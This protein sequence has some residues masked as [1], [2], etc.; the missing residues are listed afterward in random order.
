LRAF[1]ATGRLGRPSQAAEEL[2]ISTSAISHQIRALEVFLGLRM[3]ERTSSGLALTTAGHAYNK[4][5][6]DAFDA[7]STATTEQM[8]ADIGK[9]LKLHMFQSLVNLWLIP[10]LRDLTDGLPDL[11]ASI[12]SHPEVASLSASDL[13][14]A[15]VYAHEK[16]DSQ[17]AEKL[18][19]E[20]IVPVCSPEYLSKAGP[21]DSVEALVKHPLIGTVNQPAEWEEWA[22]GCGVSFRKTSRFI[23]VDYRSNALQAAQEGLGIAMDRRPF[24]DWLK[25]RG[26][27]V[28]PVPRKV[29]TSG[30]YY[31]V[32]TDRTHT[33][34][35]VRDF[36]KW[37]IE[38]CAK[39]NA[40][41]MA[42][43]D[44]AKR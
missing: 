3:F 43:S 35:R 23:H 6:C 4:R 14:A 32:A 20:V 41:A 21:I 30:A 12:V 26:K 18:F 13:D 38:L 15:V 11:N 16:P 22:A 39:T 29:W 27:L 1:E 2:R 44:G 37:L 28:E 10:N 36:R 25:S 5:I 40:G 33:L 31:L 17:F 24:G 19:D 7:I 8:R 9:P 42:P 34:Q